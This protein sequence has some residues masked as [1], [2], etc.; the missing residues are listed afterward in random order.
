MGQKSV[1]KA[2]KPNSTPKNWNRSDS[3]FGVPDSSFWIFGSSAPEHSS[4]FS[5]PFDATTKI[6]VAKIFDDDF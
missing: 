5:N 4:D 1:Y 6:I 3:S 2:Q